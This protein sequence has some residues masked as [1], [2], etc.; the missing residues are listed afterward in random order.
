MKEEDQE[1]K[2]IRGW[3]IKEP[4]DVHPNEFTGWLGLPRIDFTAA[5]RVLRVGGDPK[6]RNFAE[7]IFDEEWHP[8]EIILPNINSTKAVKVSFNHRAVIMGGEGEVLVVSRPLSAEDGWRIYGVRLTSKGC[9]RINILKDEKTP[10]HISEGAE[11]AERIQ[12]H[13]PSVDEL[14]E[15][16][17]RQRPAREVLD[18]LHKRLPMMS[19]RTSEIRVN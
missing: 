16:G 17:R 9:N 5:E 18:E 1:K 19:H 6:L 15:A 14:R 2:V 10:R 13:F 8:Q 3:G 12:Y 4:K 11:L 7:I